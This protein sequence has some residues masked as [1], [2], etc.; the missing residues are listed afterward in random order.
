MKIIKATPAYSQ[1]ISEL[2]LAELENPNPL[3][4]KKMIE[5]F[6][7][8][9]QEDNIVKEFENPRLISFLAIAEATFAG[10]IVGYENPPDAAMIHYLASKKKK[11]KS[12]LLK[13]FIKECQQRKIKKI[14]A[15]TFEFMDNNNLFKTS[16]FKLIR[17]D[18]ITDKLEMLW[19]EFHS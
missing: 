12:E 1:K 17:K 15:D 2:M 13:S 9:A 7:Q 19:H 10:F 11:A 6:R 4:P 18:K 14:I 5:K 3:F 8:H 16:G